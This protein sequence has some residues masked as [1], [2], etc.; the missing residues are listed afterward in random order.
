MR[1]GVWDNFVVTLKLTCNILILM[2]KCTVH[3][4]ST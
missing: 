3:K 4:C 1:F 2:M